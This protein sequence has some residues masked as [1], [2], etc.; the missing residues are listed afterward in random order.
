MSVSDAQRRAS[1]KY[2]KEK[3]ED[4]R[5]RVPKG[6]KDIIRAHAEKMGESVN[7]FINRAVAETMVSDNKVEQRAD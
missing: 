5:F 4:I 1:N 7:A 3:V 2:L 6:N